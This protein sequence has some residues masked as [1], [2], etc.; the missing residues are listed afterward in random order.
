MKTATITG[1]IAILLWSLLALLTV[2]SRPIPP[3]QLNA[4]C[5]GI[6]GIIGVVWMM[7][8]GKKTAPLMRLP[9]KYWFLGIGGLFGYHALYFSA[10]RLAPAAEAS[11]IAYLWPLLIVL[12]SGLLPNEQLRFGHL[13]GALIAFAGAGLI[14]ISG[15]ATSLEWSYLAGYILALLAAFTWSGYSVLSRL[16]GNVPTQAVAL[17]CLGTSVLSLLAHLSFETTQWPSSQFGWI[18]VLALGAGPVGLAFYLWDV[19]VKKGNI[20]LLGVA[21]YAAPLFSTIILVATGYAKAH[22]S[23]LIASILITIGALLAA[24]A[25][26][27]RR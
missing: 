13:I 20:Q 27:S 4:I 11:L 14:V 18:S 15:N 26:K 7:A 23:L 8:K 24:H 16:A 10:L 5:F 6:G 17:F 1:F 25:N 22:S 19:G 12:F 9:L 3:F 21:S 2:G